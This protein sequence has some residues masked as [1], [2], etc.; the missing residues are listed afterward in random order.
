M[1]FTRLNK[2]TPII[3]LYVLSL[4]NCTMLSD[5]SPLLHRLD[6]VVG[7]ASLFCISLFLLLGDLDK[8]RELV[9]RK[10]NELKVKIRQLEA[11]NIELVVKDNELKAKINLL[12]VKDTELANKDK[13]LAIAKL[14]AVITK[15]TELAVKKSKATVKE[16]TAELRSKGVELADRDRMIFDL[17]ARVI[18]LTAELEKRTEEKELISKGVDDLF[19]F[20]QSLQMVGSSR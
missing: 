19:L 6:V 10:D 2:E 1:T 15:N 14:V 17:K 13:D 16:L 9:G 12:K 3:L 5:L 4:I 18:E 20:L 7:F 8:E 11:N